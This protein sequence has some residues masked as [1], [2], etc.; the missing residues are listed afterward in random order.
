MDELDKKIE[1]TF[2]SK[3]ND[4]KLSTKFINRVNE[5][6]TTLPNKRKNYTRNIKVVLATSCCSLMLVSGIVFAKDIQE[7]IINKFKLGKGI[8]TAV[9]NGYIAETNNDYLS[10]NTNVVNPQSK[11]LLNDIIA[12]A[13]DIFN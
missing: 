1:S 5:T 11:K 13:F 4:Y 6:L 10:H 9:E 2:K 7:Y 12:S 3:S 8:Q